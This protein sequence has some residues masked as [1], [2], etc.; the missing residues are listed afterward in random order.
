MKSRR[1]WVGGTHK[2]GFI[3][4]RGSGACSPGKILK[5]GTLENAFSGILGHET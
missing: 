5:A 3:V 4:S 2:M 1:L